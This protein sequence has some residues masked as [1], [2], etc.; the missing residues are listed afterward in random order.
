MKLYQKI[1]TGGL[2]VAS[3]AGLT[4]CD[5]P[6]KT[7]GLEEIAAQDIKKIDLNHDGNYSIL[8]ATESGVG[9]RG[10]YLFKM[11]GNSFDKG[12]LI[13]NE[14]TKA[15]EVLDVNKDGY[16]DIIYAF[17]TGFGGTG[18]RILINNKDGGFTK[19]K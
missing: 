13:C 17:D 9:N 7:I 2:V 10:I 5:E 14:P 19:Q 4:G 1:L 11:K 6:K 16:D 8:A 3:L 15:I 12:V 18:M